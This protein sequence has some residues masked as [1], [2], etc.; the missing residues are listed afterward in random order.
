MPS[1][2][3]GHNIKAFRGAHSLAVGTDETRDHS[4]TVGHCFLRWKFKSSCQVRLG[5]GVTLKLSP[6]KELAAEEETGK[7][8]YCLHHLKPEGLAWRG[9]LSVWEVRT[10]L[11]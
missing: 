2:P 4:S 6:G 8:G 3:G 7:R 9:P 1:T 10:G 5:A 11:S